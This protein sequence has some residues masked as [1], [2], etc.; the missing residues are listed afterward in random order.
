MQNLMRIYYDIDVTSQALHTGDA[1][2]KD[3][4]NKIKYLGLQSRHISIHKLKVRVRRKTHKNRLTK[5]YANI[6]EQKY[7]LEKQILQDALSFSST[8]QDQM[9]FRVK[10]T[11]WYKKVTAAEV[12]H[13]TKCIPIECRARQTNE[14]HNELLVKYQNQTYFLTPRSRIVIKLGTPRDCDELLPIIL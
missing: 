7:A 8:A 9:E 13:L 2:R 4:Q 11:P 10:K 6:T 1:T 14:C 12:I 5:F 3:V